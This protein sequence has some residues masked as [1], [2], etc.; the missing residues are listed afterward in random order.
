MRDGALVL[1]SQ[2]LYTHCFFWNFSFLISQGTFLLPELMQVFTEISPSLKVAFPDH[3]FLNVSPITLCVDLFLFICYTYRYLTECYIIQVF[4]YCL[5]LPLEQKLPENRGIVLFYI[6]SPGRV[7]P[8]EKVPI[9]CI[10]VI[11][12]T[13]MT[14]CLFNQWKK[15]TLINKLFEHK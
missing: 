12:V 4:V 10:V 2:E 1:P 3:P 8:W 15:H 5:S 7:P 6:H 11:S 14:I 9:E 13:L